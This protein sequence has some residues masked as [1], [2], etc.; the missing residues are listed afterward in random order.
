VDQFK[1]ASDSPYTLLPRYR[2]VL[3]AVGNIV[4]SSEVRMQ[5]MLD[6][7]TLL[8][9]NPAAL[10]EPGNWKDFRESASAVP[11]HLTTGYTR[12]MWAVVDGADAL[13]ALLDRLVDDDVPDVRK[14]AARAIRNVASQGTCCSQIGA[15]VRRR[16]IRPLCTALES[17]ASGRCSVQDSSTESPR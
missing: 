1:C 10:L 7:E 11:A 13:P 9:A 8:L 17:D 5:A 6:H 2:P 15:R 12:A 3:L 16:C 14:N 4:F